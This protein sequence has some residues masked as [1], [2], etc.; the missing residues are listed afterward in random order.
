MRAHSSNGWTHQDLTNARLLRSW[1]Q[2][3]SKFPPLPYQME[4]PDQI[5]A[6]I[7]NLTSNVLVPRITNCH[8]ILRRP[9]NNDCSAK[10][11]QSFSYLGENPRDII[12]HTVTLHLNSL[13][14]ISI[15]CKSWLSDVIRIR[16]VSW[17]LPWRNS[18]TPH[19]HARFVTF[20]PPLGS[21]L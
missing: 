8:R 10:C 20:A 9:I 14:S 12:W 7:L 6:S 19:P 18:V 5:G 15:G 11:R 3:Q 2:R 4:K 13:G 16:Q 1:H 21:R 17:S